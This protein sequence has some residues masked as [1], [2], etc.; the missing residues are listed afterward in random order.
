[1]TGDF[2]AAASVSRSQQTS[3]FLLLAA[4]SATAEMRC[5]LAHP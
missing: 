4:A 2:E 3:H 5:A 1:M